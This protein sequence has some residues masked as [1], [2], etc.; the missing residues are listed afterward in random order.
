MY[1]TVLSNQNT[2]PIS[3]F[4]NF[5]FGRSL[6][7]CKNEI[8]E[9]SCCITLIDPQKNWEILN[10]HSYGSYCIPNAPLKMGELSSLPDFD[11]KRLD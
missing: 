9:N 10:L 4:H 5:D 8:I 2:A 11:N 7:I 6:K 1:D 3:A